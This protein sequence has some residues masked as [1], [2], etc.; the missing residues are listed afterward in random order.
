MPISKRCALSVASAN[1][2]GFDEYVGEVE[3]LH[4]RARQG[5][6]R[7]ARTV[8]RRRLRETA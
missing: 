5:E 3:K 6:H 4:A 8:L 1:L 7:A 2:G